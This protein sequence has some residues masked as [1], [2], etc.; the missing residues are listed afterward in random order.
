MTGGH[1]LRE[2]APISDSA[3]QLLDD[4]AR[5][6]LTV[7]LGARAVVDFSGPH[8]W[9]YSASSLGRVVPIAGTGTDDVG[10][11]RRNV[12]PV[13]ELRA[14]FP[15]ARSELANHDRGAEDVDLAGL[16]EAA[17]RIASAEN[18]AVFHG[19]EAA[20][21]VG[22]TTATGYS[23]VPRVANFQDYPG[24]VAKAVE[25]LLRGGVGGPFALALGPSDYTAVIETAENGG[26]PM[27]HHVRSIIGG[28][29]V[30][31]P[32]VR[33]AVVAS[34][35]GGDFLFESGQDLSIGYHSHDDTV[36]NLY[37][38]ESFSFRVATPEAAVALAELA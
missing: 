12:T 14:D 35:R 6:R 27:A 4:E 13:V 24:R 10:I 21:I 25:T 1:L 8:G 18:L 9:E 23:P 36:V 2:H 33:G 7:S 38:H 26:Y 15:V 28:P 34:T 22:L 32:G 31:A 17:L 37:L 20:G 19:M 3:W 30:W 16:Q 29:I 11:S 5:T